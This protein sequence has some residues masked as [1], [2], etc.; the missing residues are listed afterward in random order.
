LADIV[1]ALNEELQSR[2]LRRIA[3]LGTRFAMESR[4]FGRLADVELA[5]PTG[6]EAER[7]HAA[8]MRVAETGAGA[9]EDVEALRRIAHRL[10][11]EEGAEAVL[12]AGTDFSIVFNEESA[13]FPA[14]D[15]TRVHVEAIMRRLL[16]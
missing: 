6:E 8:Y 13:G 11:A 7:I 4:L 5:Q 10:C 15:S 2:R 14:I 1:D 9:A 16:D 3:L 12:L